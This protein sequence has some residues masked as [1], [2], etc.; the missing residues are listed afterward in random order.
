MAKSL[1]KYSLE[2]TTKYSNVNFVEQTCKIYLLHN[3]K[4]KITKKNPQ[5]GTLENITEKN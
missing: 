4:Y 2:D 3:S 1:R 5:T